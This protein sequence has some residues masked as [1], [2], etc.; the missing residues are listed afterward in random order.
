MNIEAGFEGLLV[1]AAQL[2][3]R[4]RAETWW[5]TGETEGVHD[6]N[7][8]V[9]LLWR[10]MLDARRSSP[11]RIG[12]RLFVPVDRGARVFPVRRYGKE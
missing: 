4:H 8:H 7:R 9:K 10:A 3:G 2:E 1:S 11:K 5:I 6:E 12:D